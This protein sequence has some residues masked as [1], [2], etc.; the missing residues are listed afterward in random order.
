[1]AEIGS[2]TSIVDI[3]SLEYYTAATYAKYDHVEGR[4]EKKLGP[5]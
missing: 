1:M 4:T 5:N 2:E 3:Y